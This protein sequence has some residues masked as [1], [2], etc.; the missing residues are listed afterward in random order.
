M[1]S[2]QSFVTEFEMVEHLNSTLNSNFGLSSVNELVGTHGIA[3]IVLY[4]KPANE[5][6]IK[7]LSLINPR[8]A[9]AL[10]SLPIHTPFSTENFCEL[11]LSSKRTIKEVLFTFV[12]TG[13]C[14]Y[15]QSTGLWTKITE[16]VKISSHLYAVEAKLRDWKRAL[17]QAYRYLDYANESWVL[18]DEMY[19]KPATKNLEIFAK[20]N[21]GLATISRDSELRQIFKPFPKKPRSE[22][23]VWFANAH[24]A[25]KIIFGT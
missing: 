21:I 25:K 13:F 2:A 7:A 16:P 6:I 1:N 11:N 24:L 20:Y 18:L 5:D 3:D 12:G 19:S 8:W 17:K 14:S 15:D 10:K 22:Y 23:A 4:D 9:Y